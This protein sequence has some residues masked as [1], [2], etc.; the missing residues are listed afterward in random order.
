MSPF[1]RS[2]LSTCLCKSRRYTSAWDAHKGEQK[3]RYQAKLAALNLDPNIV[4][5]VA[6]HFF[7]DKIPL[8]RGQR[9]QRYSKPHCPAPRRSIGETWSGS[10]G[11]FKCVGYTHCGC[12][13]RQGFVEI[14][15]KIKG[16]GKRQH[17]KQR[18]A[19]RPSTTAAAKTYA[20]GAAVVVAAAAAAAAAG[21]AAA[22]AA[23]GEAAGLV[24]LQTSL[25][26]TK[27]NNNDNNNNN[28]NTKK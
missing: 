8:Q 3:N 10:N 15:E 5:A 22:A 1:G 13:R 2:T 7:P 18:R 19:K 28:N 20:T 9:V 16:R 17:S 6:R 14:V 27:K 12:P 11:T 24:A 25:Q 21:E 4:P 26:T 23:A